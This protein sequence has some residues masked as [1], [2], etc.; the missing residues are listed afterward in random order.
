MKIKEILGFCDDI[1]EIHK[2][3][4]EVVRNGFS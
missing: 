3:E 2:A 1:L 4:K